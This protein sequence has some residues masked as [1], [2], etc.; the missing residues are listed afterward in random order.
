[1]SNDV[2]C[3]K[4]NEK[5]DPCHHFDD[6]Y[7]DGR[8]LV[9]KCETCS[10]LFTII[11]NYVVTYSID[12]SCGNIECSHNSKQK[13]KKLDASCLGSHESCSNYRPTE[14]LIKQYEQDYGEK[15]NEGE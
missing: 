13:F 8:T 10:T 11:Q 6:I 12:D 3:P 7:G 15:Y 5:V 1:M 2:N 14:D 9:V 4:C